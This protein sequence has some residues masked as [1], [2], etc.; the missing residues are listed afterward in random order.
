MFKTLFR[1]RKKKNR[2]LIQPRKDLGETLFML[3]YL[4]HICC[5]YS[6]Y[7]LNIF[8]INTQNIFW[9]KR[10]FIYNIVISLCNIFFFDLPLYKENLCILFIHSMQYTK[11]FSF[12]LSLQFLLTQWM[13]SFDLSTDSNYLNWTNE[14][15]GKFNEKCIICRRWSNTDEKSWLF[16]LKKCQQRNTTIH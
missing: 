1:S 6:E 15:N 10:Y 3:E 16:Y 4:Y 2:K 9:L 11:I 8:Q 13:N 5:I 12:S 7:I 14:L